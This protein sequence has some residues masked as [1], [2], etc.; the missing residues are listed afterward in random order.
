MAIENIT[1]PDIGDFDGV[2]IIEV[3]AQVGDTVE[4]EDS[5]LTLESDKATMEIPSPAAGTITEWKVGLGDKVS[6]GDLICV[7][8][9]AEGSA[10]EAP[11]LKEE[12]PKAETAA[13]PAP[14]ASA[15]VSDGDIH[16]EVVVLGG[17]P[18]GYTAAFRAADLGKKVVLI[19]R[20]DN[21][22]GVCL[23][24]GCIP[25]KALLHCAEVINEAE[26]MAHAGISFGKLTIDI[27]QMRDYK[28]DVIKKLTGGLADLA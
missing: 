7:M 17:G 14:Q 28:H 12:A 22:G 2:E 16:G 11:A 24:V 27:N 8:D 26:E 3:L 25:S 13:T 23:N 10:T 5:L 21:I 9:V 18:G 19:E 20:Y 15:E 6:T 1:L 4:E